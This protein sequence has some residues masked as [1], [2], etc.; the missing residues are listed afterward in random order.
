MIEPRGRKYVTTTERTMAA[1]K[2]IRQ[3]VKGLLNLITEADD[4]L[5][6]DPGEYTFTKDRRAG[7]GRHLLK[8]MSRY[9]G[10]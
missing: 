5:A 6:S 3:V 2:R 4:V 7:A 8:D 9:R 10:K 1:E